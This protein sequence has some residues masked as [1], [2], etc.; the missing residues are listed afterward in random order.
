V[1]ALLAAREASTATNAS[2]HQHTRADTSREAASSHL[3]ALHAQLLGIIGSE[4][5]DLPSPDRPSA[6]LSQEPVS[7]DVV[8]LLHGRRYSSPSNRTA[9]RSIYPPRL[10]PADKPQLCDLFDS[11]GGVLEGVAGVF[12]DD[13]DHALNSSMGSLFSGPKLLETG[14]NAE[15]FEEETVAGH[16]PGVDQDDEDNWSVDKEKS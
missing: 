6:T 3:A 2:T 15:D 5:P 14:L 7:P 12:G 1:T 16:V 13:V 9:P 4:L 8:E 10:Q 11:D